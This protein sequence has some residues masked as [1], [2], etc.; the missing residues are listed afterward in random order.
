MELIEQR[1]EEPRFLKTLILDRD[2][3]II[4]DQEYGADIAQL[5][6]IGKSLDA[7]RK[8][9]RFSVNLF[10][11]TN[12]GGL[13]LGRFSHL[14]L[15][16]FNLALQNSLYENGIVI[17]GVLSC[18]HHENALDLSNR[19]CNCRKPKTGML[20]RIQAI[21][22]SPKENMAMIGDSWRDLEVASNFD[23]QFFD[24]CDEN[25]WRDSTDWC[26]KS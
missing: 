18:P 4:L 25:G 6:L 24:A 9:S 13:A 23:V 11:A 16:N 20:E 5:Q 22:K 14:E 3:T 15:I 8:I 17:N 26:E 19:I 21:T 7:L 2:G 1:F 10:I 12:Q